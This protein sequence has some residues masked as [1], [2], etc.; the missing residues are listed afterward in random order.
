MSEL[1]HSETRVDGECRAG[2]GEALRVDYKR[3][4]WVEYTLPFLLSPLFRSFYLLHSTD[5]E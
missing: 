3:K 1:L 4:G 5:N 2:K